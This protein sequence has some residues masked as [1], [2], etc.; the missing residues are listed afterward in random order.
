MA[1]TKGFEPFT[2]SFGGRRSIPV[3]LRE[4]AL[5]YLPDGFKAVITEFENK[6]GHR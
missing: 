3:E 1:L 4:Q 6:Y 5:T 2:F